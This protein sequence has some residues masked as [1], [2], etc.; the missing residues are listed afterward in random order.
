M[1][2]QY[3]KENVS[4]IQL[5]ETL[6]YRYNRRKGRNP[7][8]YEHPNGDKVIISDK[9]NPSMEVYFTRNK[10]DDK[11]T[12]VDFVKN[13]LP[14]FNVHYNS[15]WEGVIKV[16]SEFSGQAYQ[17]P[18]IKP[19]PIKKLDE[20]QKPFQLHDFVLKD[21]SIKDLGYLQ[22]DRQLSRDTLKTF[23]PFIKLVNEKGRRY[24]N[25]GF[26]YR[27]P[28]EDQITGFEVVNHQF[29]GHAK[30]SQRRDSVWMADLSSARQLIANL[31]IGESAIDAMS[32]YQLYRNKFNFDNSV[33]ISTGGN[34]LKNQV[35][36]IIKAYP[37]TKIHTIFDN[38]FS[39][40][41]YDIFLAG[42]KANKEISIR[43]HQESVRFELKKGAFEI[44]VA[45]ISLARFERVT[46]IRSGV[47]A[48]KSKGKDFNEMLQNRFGEKEQLKPTK[49]FKR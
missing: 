22:Y 49:S 15:E 3:F 10:Y 27:I 14:M 7:L 34:V 47:R 31:Y 37:S 23:M 38:D 35:Q 1:D 30:G 6:G 32:F 11:G 12:V 8:Q 24:Q 42:I 39:G 25:I 45:Q 28:G 40:R 36:N 4:I 26:T 29:K 44:P 20:A 21:P 46:G 5:V 16:L 9:L 48:H 19:Q 41:M 33:F 13:R 18:K 43:K 2:L 17:Q